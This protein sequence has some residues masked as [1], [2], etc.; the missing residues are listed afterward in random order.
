MI[1]RISKVIKKIPISIRFLGYGMFI[2]LLVRYTK[3]PY[4]VYFEFMLIVQIAIYMYVS[5]T[6]EIPT[7]TV[8]LFVDEEHID[9]TERTVIPSVGDTIVIDCGNLVK[10]ID[11]NHDW[12]TS[13]LVQVNCISVKEGA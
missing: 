1:K 8:S 4:S 13:D 11:I 5:L 10:V 6:Y 7:I 2:L 9:K 12:S 3:L